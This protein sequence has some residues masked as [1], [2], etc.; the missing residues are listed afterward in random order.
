MTLNSNITL[1]K[2]KRRLL[3]HVWIA[4]VLLLLGIAACGII[5]AFVLLMGF[6]LSEADRYARLVKSFLLPPTSGVKVIDGRINVLVMGK[7]GLGHDAP[8]LTDTLVLVSVDTNKKSITSISIP[9]D[10]WI[11]ELRAKINASYHYGKLKEEDGGLILAKS[12]VEKVTGQSIPYAAV[13]DFMAFKDIVDAVGGIKVN[14]QRNFTDERYPI[15]G[16]E[17]DTCGGD[18]D[19]KCRYQTVEFRTGSQMMD[20]ETAL[21][22]VRSR[23][24]EGDEGTD[25][26]RETRQQKVIAAI[27]EKLLNPLVYLNTLKLEALIKIVSIYVE[28]DITQAEAAAMA[29]YAFESRRNITSLVFPKELITSPPISKIYDNQYVFVP[30]GGTW[31][32]IH[33][34]VMSAL[35]K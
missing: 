12:I 26:A 20:G 22:F 21:K 14:V 27:K 3:K 29:R 4:R 13:V 33:E 23:N 31:D 19:L 15:A 30:I 25:I 9:R 16:R 7:G 18:P 35:E 6:R 8:D 17:N 2:L 34:W 32:K 24:A 5:L 11:A 1:S 10:L 28:S